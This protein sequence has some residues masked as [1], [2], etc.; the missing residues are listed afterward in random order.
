M[1]SLIAKILVKQAYFAVHICIKGYFIVRVQCGPY[2]V[3]LRNCNLYR[4][5]RKCGQWASVALI[6]AYKIAFA[7]I[8]TLVAEEFPKAAPVIALLNG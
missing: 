2:L 5:A 6:G 3:R 1:F 7:L 8:S 4:L